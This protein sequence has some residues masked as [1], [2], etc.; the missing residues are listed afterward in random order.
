MTARKKKPKAKPPREW[1]LCE[2]CGRVVDRNLDVLGK[3]LMCKYPCHSG[4]FVRV[5]EVPKKV[6]GRNVK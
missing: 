3:P 5:R 6:R 1:W 2:G 4:L